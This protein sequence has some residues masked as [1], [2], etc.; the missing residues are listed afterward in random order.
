LIKNKSMDWV[1]RSADLDRHSVIEAGSYPG[2][3]GKQRQTKPSCM[4]VAANSAPPTLR[5]LPG[6]CFSYLTSP[7]MF[8]LTSLEF[9]FTD[10]WSSKKRSWACSAKSEGRMPNS[11]KIATT[12][13]PVFGRVID[14]LGENDR[15][16]HFTRCSTPVELYCVTAL[17]LWRLFN[18]FHISHL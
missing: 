7:A 5:F 17:H 11:A 14:H 4:N 6:C 15:L 12:W 9:H 16:G 13:T 18:R 10:R 3:S 2:I 1:F 8:S